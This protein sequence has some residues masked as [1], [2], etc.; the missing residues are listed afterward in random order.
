M[1]KTSQ[2]ADYFHYSQCDFL[3][4][5]NFSLFFRDFLDMKDQLGDKESQD[6]TGQR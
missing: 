5:Y 4:I 3:N 6:A 1:E 2:S